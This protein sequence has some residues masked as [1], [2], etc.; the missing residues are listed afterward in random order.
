MKLLKSTL[1]GSKGGSGE[2]SL[3]PEEIEDLWQIFN[4]IAVGDE[5]SASTFRK[6]AKESNSGA[7]DQQK[8]KLTLRVRVESIDFDPEGG[9][10]RLAGITVAEN[11]HVRLGSHH[12]LELEL[13]RQFTLSKDDWDSVSISRLQEATGGPT[14]NADVA[15][16]LMQPG[17]A[18]LCLM[19]GS[20]TITR[21]R[22]EVQLG[23]KKGAAATMGAK[24]AVDISGMSKFYR[25][26]YGMLTSAASSV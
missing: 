10:L 15:A 2:V 23:K 14:S 26:Y 11:E 18:N 12:S 24:K 22:L 4:L 9:Q 17:L 19:S 13:H 5:V 7:V 6:V 16:I 3:I 8:M 20:M 1:H 21:A 25:Q